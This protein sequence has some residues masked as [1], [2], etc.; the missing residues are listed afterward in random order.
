TSSTCST[1]SPP[2]TRKPPCGTTS[3]NASASAGPATGS[4]PRW[5]R[6]AGRRSGAPP[7]TAAL[8]P[9][10]R[11]NWACLS[12]LSTRPGAASWPASGSRSS[13]WRMS[14]LMKPR[15]ACP[16]PERW[17]QHLDGTASPAEQA[18]LTAHLDVCPACQKTL[19]TLAASG[20]SLLRQARQMGQQPARTDGP[21]APPDGSATSAETLLGAAQLDEE[22]DFLAPSAK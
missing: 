2:R 21:N 20:D 17:R 8:P 11:V 18:E 1:S 22:L 10:Q 19:E 6:R 7:W 14:K 15:S 13:N 5:S 16:P 4:A 12:A 3:T 9:R